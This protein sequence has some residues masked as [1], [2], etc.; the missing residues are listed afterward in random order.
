MPFIGACIH[1]PAPPPNQIIY[2]KL[3]TPINFSELSTFASVTVKGFL[4]S[5]LQSPELSLVDGTQPVTTSY[6]LETT[7]LK[8][9]KTS[10]NIW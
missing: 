8:I 10:M 3:K 1:K 4:T 7:S 5:E 6:S 9:N 2:A